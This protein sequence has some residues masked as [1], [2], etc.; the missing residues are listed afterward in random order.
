MHVNPRTSNVIR[1]SNSTTFES[2]PHCLLMQLH[3]P[4]LTRLYMFLDWLL[5]HLPPT[6][7]CFVP[8][9]SCYIKFPIPPFFSFL[10]F[11]LSV[12]DICLLSISTQLNHSKFQSAIS[13]PQ[14]NSRSLIN[15][16][17]GRR[18]QA[19]IYLQIRREARLHCIQWMPS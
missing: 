17:H 6:S 18:R 7:T 12:K 9:T 2:R 13:I 1:V 8:A 3:F 11:L 10:F 15:R 16:N 14:Y 19:R 4:L 5:P